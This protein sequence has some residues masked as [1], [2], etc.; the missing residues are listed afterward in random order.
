MQ[1]EAR[2]RYNP[3]RFWKEHFDQQPKFEPGHWFINSKFDPPFLHTNQPSGFHGEARLSKLT[4]MLMM[5]IIGSADVARLGPEQYYD[6]N[7]LNYRRLQA[8]A[9]A[10]PL[11]ATLLEQCLVIDRANETICLVPVD[12]VQEIQTRLLASPEQERNET[13]GSA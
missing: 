2:I 3:S 11:V 10:N 6:L 9:N 12:S 4:G 1:I 13:A 8:L 5:D 7:E